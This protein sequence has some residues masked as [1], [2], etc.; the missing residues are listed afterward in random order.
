MIT[1]IKIPIPKGSFRNAFVKL[2]NRSKVT[3]ALINIA[4]GID[5]DE[6]EKKIND[7]RIV[8]GSVDKKVFRVSEIEWLLKNKVLDIDLIEEIIRKLENLIEEKH[9]SSSLTWEYKK[10]AGKR[11]RI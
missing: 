7:A 11:C 1:G 5:F 6:K 3:I 10:K 2:G 8:L 9:R 4:L